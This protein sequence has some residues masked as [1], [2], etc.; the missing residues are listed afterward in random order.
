MKSVMKFCEGLRRVGKL[1]EGANKYGNSVWRCFADSERYLIDFA[2]EF[3]A[4]GWKQFDTDQDAAYFGCWV[5]PSRCLTLTYAEGDWTLVDC[6][7]ADTY[8]AEVRRWIEFYGEGRESLVI[9]TDGTA[10][11]FRQDRTSQFFAVDPVDAGQG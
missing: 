5:N 10:T 7:S 11:E 6:P 4:E 1:D 8:N 3:T 9:D 2:E